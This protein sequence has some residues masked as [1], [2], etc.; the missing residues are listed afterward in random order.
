MSY[1][2]TFSFENLELLKE[3]IGFTLQSLVSSTIGAIKK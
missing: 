1:E 2:L 3:Y